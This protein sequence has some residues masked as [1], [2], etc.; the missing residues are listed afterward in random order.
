[1]KPQCSGVPLICDRCCEKIEPFTPY[2]Q[3]EGVGS[4]QWCV[5]CEDGHPADQSIVNQSE[6]DALGEQK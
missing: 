1:M 3:P 4:E 5:A 2:Y 6:A